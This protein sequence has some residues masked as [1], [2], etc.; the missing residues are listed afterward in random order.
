MRSR[1]LHG[2]CGSGVSGG[3]LVMVGRVL[4]SVLTVI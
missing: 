4:E 1:E 3:D 2:N